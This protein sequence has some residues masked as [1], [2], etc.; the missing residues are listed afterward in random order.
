MLYAHIAKSI[1]PLPLIVYNGISK[2]NVNYDMGSINF[3]GIIFTYITSITSNALLE[4]NVKLFLL[5]KMFE[6]VLTLLIIVIVTK[7]KTSLKNPR[8]T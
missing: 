5:T 4:I 2:T 8:T 3:I 6:S 7:G 1:F